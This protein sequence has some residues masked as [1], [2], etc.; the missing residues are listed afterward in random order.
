MFDDPVSSLDCD[1]LFIVSNLIKTLFD[2]IRACS[3]YIKQIFVLTHN[4]YFHKEVTYNKNRCQGGAMNEE[5]FWTIKKINQLSKVQKHNMNPI[6]TSYEL[7]W[8]E[9]SDELNRSNHNLTIQNTLRRILEHYFQILG[10]INRDGI[11]NYFEGEEKI[12]CSSLFSWI[13]DGSHYPNDDIYISNDSSLVDKQL[14][15]FK[16]I[17]EKSGHIAH[18]NMMMGVTNN[19]SGIQG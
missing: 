1:I 13:N 7:L 19:P 10:G 14:R 2:E 4:V 12:I 15:I 11:C 8:N 6:R 16:E 18:Y 5:T 3:G 17:F 9:V